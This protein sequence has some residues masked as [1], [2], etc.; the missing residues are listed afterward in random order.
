[1]GY[2]H[3]RL[4]PPDILDLN[5]LW[6]AAKVM[7]K[8]Y[9]VASEISD[10]EM[11]KML[12]LPWKSLPSIVEYYY[13]W[14]TTDRFVQQVSYWDVADSKSDGIQHIFRNSSDT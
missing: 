3:G 9:A 4:A 7:L 14:K 6:T 10:C 5:C 11:W 13:M 12:Q 2:G 1:M 8:N